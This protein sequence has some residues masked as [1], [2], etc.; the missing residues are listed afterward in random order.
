MEP[1]PHDRLAV[2]AR[3]MAEPE[4]LLAQTRLRMEETFMHTPP[5]WPER[6]LAALVLSDR[7]IVLFLLAMV[8]ACGVIAGL[9][10]VT[11]REIDRRVS[12]VHQRSGPTLSQRLDVIEQRLQAL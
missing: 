7:G 8:F 11:N 3:R 10:L 9:T 6:F 2:F 4:Q 12:Q 5:L 1:D